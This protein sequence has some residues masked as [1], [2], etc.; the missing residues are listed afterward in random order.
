MALHQKRQISSRNA[1]NWDKKAKQVRAEYQK[2][3]IRFTVPNLGG[4]FL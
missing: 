3:V 2:A 4:R 1:N